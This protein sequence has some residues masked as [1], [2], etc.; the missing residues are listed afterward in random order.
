M[1]KRVSTSVVGIILLMLIMYFGG[2]WIAFGAGLLAALSWY[3]YSR[4]LQHK[5]YCAP[6]IS[7]ALV[8]GL[9]VFIGGYLASAWLLALYVLL[10]LA[11]IFYGFKRQISWGNLTALIFAFGY[12]AFG[13]TA[14]VLLRNGDFERKLDI[15]L[16]Q[17][18]IE[19]NTTLDISDLILGDTAYF[20]CLFFAFLIA[21]VSDSGA[22]FVG[23]A[24]GK[25][26]LAPNI[27]PSKTIEGAIGG[28]I[29]A[30]IVCG[31]YAKL[32]LPD[33]LIALLIIALI[34]CIGGQI[35]DL[36]ESALKRWAG[37]KD[38]GNIL[39][40]HGGI[41]DRFD[42]MMIIAPLVYIG[43]MVI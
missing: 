23:R 3:E 8:L 20:Y 27:S 6:K 26:K 40:G 37:V 18:I 11:L 16:I 41:L 42:S 15:S 10:G 35:G 14:F 22:F 1:F 25:H 13:F 17:G 30:L 43:F 9:T 7:G 5:N 12:Y 21:W 31:V 38:S 24:I 34:A 39:P 4:I 28:L 29:C 33:H 2:I 32:F 36:L 19:G